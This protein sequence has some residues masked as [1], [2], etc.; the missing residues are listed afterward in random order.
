M[1]TTLTA[2]QVGALGIL[3]TDLQTKHQAS[4]AKIDK[5]RLELWVAAG[6]VAG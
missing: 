5:A 6:E 3:K 4:L 1:A 2:E